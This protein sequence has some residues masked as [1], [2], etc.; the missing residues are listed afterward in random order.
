M[1]IGKEVEILDLEN[2]PYIK[3][4]VIMETKNLLVLLT[5]KGIK[6]IIK[7]NKKIVIYINNEKK[8]KIIGD[9]ISKRPWEYAI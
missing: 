6:K 1:I 9:K 5:N 3:G 2:K 4:K 7:Q 8:I